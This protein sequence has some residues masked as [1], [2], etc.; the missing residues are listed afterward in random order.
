[1]EV[2]CVRSFQDDKIV[3]VVCGRSLQSRSFGR[4][5]IHKT[6]VRYLEQRDSNHNQTYVSMCLK[7]L[8]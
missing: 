6:Y 3:E 4:Q 2:V 5:T 7:K 8:I 1:M